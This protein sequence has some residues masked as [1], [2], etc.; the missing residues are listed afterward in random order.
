MG[1]AVAAIV[2]LLGAIFAIYSEWRAADE[3][4]D[5]YEAKLVEEHALG[6]V[7]ARLYELFETV[8]GE[9]LTAGQRLVLLRAGAEIGR[10]ED[11]LVSLQAVEGLPEDDARVV[12]PLPGANVLG[13]T[14]RH[15]TVFQY[16]GGAH[17]CTTLTILALDPGVSE[18][19]RI[20]A[21]NYPVFFAEMDGD[22]ALE[23]VTFDNAFAYWRASFAE[24]AAPRVVLK[25]DRASKA[26]VPAAE[27]MRTPPP[28][29]AALRAEAQRWKAHERWTNANYDVAAR[30]PPGLLAAVIELI[31]AGN[32]DVALELAT[33]AWPEDLASART[34]FL[35][36]LLNCRLRK[37]VYWQGIA[38]LNG[39]SAEPPVASCPKV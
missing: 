37:S 31:Y 23:I 28:D 6:D 35:E 30:I 22:A 26:Y 8:K 29:A 38:R 25:F 39:L 27:I 11:R 16:S 21:G 7:A 19:A 13:G 15:L 10:V 1:G 4:S 20:E 24:S 3:G 17:C 34:A 2:L 9:R 12:S 5:R 36:E 18:V 33:Q 14:A 32:L